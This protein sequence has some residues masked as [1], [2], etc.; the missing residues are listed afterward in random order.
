MGNGVGEQYKNIRI[1]YF[2][3]KGAGH[4]AKDLGLTVAFLTDILI[5]PLHS[6]VPADYN[7]THI[8]LPFFLKYALPGW[9]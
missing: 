7:Y 9:G 5:S 6:L 1:A 4:L 2:L 8:H 3:L